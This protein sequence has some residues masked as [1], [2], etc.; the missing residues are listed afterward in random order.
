MLAVQ[1]AR[2]NKARTL[3]Q[4]SNLSHGPNMM[5]DFQYHERSGYLS[6][7]V[8][9]GH[10]HHLN[11]PR[12]TLMRDLLAKMVLMVQA[13]Y[14]DMPQEGRPAAVINLYVSQYY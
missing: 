6:R 5:V 3:L 1:Q 13:R 4:G 9:K 14:W 8:L 11:V 7:K 2:A 10:L 12:K